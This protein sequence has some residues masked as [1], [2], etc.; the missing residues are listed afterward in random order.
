MNIAL[1]ESDNK[2]TEE[3]KTIELMMAENSPRL[4]KVSR[5]IILKENNLKYIPA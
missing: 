3:K 2:E 1:R 4:V 5:K